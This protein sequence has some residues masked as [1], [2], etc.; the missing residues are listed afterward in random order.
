MFAYVHIHTQFPIIFTCT[1]SR[2]NVH[3]W[4]PSAGC[5]DCPLSHPQCVD[6]VLL[7]SHS[8]SPH[9]K[10]FPYCCV[11]CG[12]SGFLLYLISCS[13]VQNKNGN[14]WS[15]NVLFIYLAIY[16]FVC[17]YTYHLAL[18]KILRNCTTHNSN[19]QRFCK[20]IICTLAVMISNGSQVS[21]DGMKTI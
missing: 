14:N 7:K 13:I 8:L 11:L 10:E 3:I 12:S 2:L 15:L 17:F 9:F 4:P 6:S 5:V 16:W 19:I 18:R 1:G 21:H 20:K